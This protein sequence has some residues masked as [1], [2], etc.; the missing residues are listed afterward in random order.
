MNTIRLLASTLLLA[1][2]AAAFAAP[3]PVL[4]QPE[5]G[6]GGGD[7]TI[8]LQTSEGASCNTPVV[9]NCGSCAVSCPSGKAASCKPGIAV[10]PQAGASCVTS[11]ECKCQ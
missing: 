3:T 2:S 10:G 8:N 11:P 1:L 4:I 9:G 5:A 6:H 7:R